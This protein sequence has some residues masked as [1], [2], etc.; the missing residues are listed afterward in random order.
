MPGPRYVACSAELD[1]G[2]GGG[3]DELVP[4]DAM[5]DGQDLAGG[6]RLEDINNWRDKNQWVARSW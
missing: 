3:S 5:V 4:E 2:G 6:P 1:I